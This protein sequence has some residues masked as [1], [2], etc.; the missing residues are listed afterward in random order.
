MGLW[1]FDLAW[2]CQSLALLTAEWNGELYSVASSGLPHL[3][4]RVA[5]EMYSNWLNMPVGVMN[6]LLQCFYCP[7]K[8]LV[9]MSGT[10]CEN[11]KQ[12]QKDFNTQSV[13]VNSPQLWMLPENGSKRRPVNY[14]LPNSQNDNFYGLSKVTRAT[15]TLPKMQLRLFFVNI[16]ESNLCVKT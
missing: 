6:L 8:T 9:A 11:L 16:Y 13:S 7:F 2:L 14:F 4:N 3:A 5:R 1:P 10:G 12:R 15:L